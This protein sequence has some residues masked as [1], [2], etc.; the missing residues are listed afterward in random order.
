METFYQF[1]E[2][3]SKSCLPSQWE[4]I[5]ISIYWTLY[6]KETYENLNIVGNYWNYE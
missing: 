2:I 4:E 5:C 3:E 6:L 1:F